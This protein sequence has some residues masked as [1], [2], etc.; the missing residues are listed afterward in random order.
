MKIY[1]NSNGIIF[2]GKISDLRSLLKQYLLNSVT[3]KELINK[4]LH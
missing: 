2:T 1:V 4:H 3:V